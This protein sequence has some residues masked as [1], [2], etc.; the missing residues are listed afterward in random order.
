MLLTKQGE[1][2]LLAKRREERD[3]LLHELNIVCKQ[4]NEEVELFSARGEVI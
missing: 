2:L 3:I 1:I 4:S